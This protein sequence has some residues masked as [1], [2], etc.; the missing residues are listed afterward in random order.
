[1]N[2][3]LQKRIKYW[4]DK[5]RDMPNGYFVSLLIGEQYINAD[6]RVSK[7]RRKKRREKNGKTN[8]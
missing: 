7:E 6:A 4:K 1:M 3:V 8:K 2:S 5:Y